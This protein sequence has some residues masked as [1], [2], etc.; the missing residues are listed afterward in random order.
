MLCV[1][2]PMYSP[3]KCS[4]LP[5]PHLH[6]ESLTSNGGALWA[7]LAH[8]GSTLYLAGGTALALQIGHRQ[9]VDFDFFSPKPIPKNALDNLEKMLTGSVVTP[10]IATADELTVSVDDIKVSLVYYPF[11]LLFPLVTEAG[12][13]LLSAREIATTKAYTIGRRGAL[14]DY[15]D[16]YYCLQGTITTLAQILTDAQ[17]KYAHAFTD[18]LFLE[19]L[20][21]LDDVVDEP[22][23]FLTAPVTRA[24]LIAYFKAEIKKLRIAA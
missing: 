22:I 16:L 14:K 9:S 11:P 1:K 12:H 7:K 17:Q 20:I 6:L 10:L 23:H 24:E 3:V 5:M 18:R 13:T 8:V 21:Y 15:L 19:Q 4:L 2:E